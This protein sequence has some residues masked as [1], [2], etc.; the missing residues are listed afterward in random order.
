MGTKIGYVLFFL[1]VGAIRVLPACADDW[2]RPVDVPLMQAIL[3]IT[4]QSININITKDA[5]TT[6]Y[7]LQN[8]GAEDYSCVLAF[9]SP[10]TSWRGWSENNPDRRYAELA[11]TVNG[12]PV[13]YNNRSTAFLNGRNVTD[14]LAHY[15]IS[16]DIAGRPDH[17]LQNTPQSRTLYAELIEKGFFR[18]D[19]LHSPIENLLSY[20]EAW[21]VGGTYPLEPT[22]SVK[23]TYSWT[24][25]FPATVVQDIS[26]M[27]RPMWGA[28]IANYCS[29]FPLSIVSS[30]S[31]EHVAKG[32]GLDEKLMEEEQF[33]IR[34]LILP[35]DSILWNDIQGVV[36]I[37][38]DFSDDKGSSPLVFL[39]FGDQ[40]MSGVGRVKITRESTNR[41]DTV[42]VVTVQR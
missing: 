39:S 26:Y 27:F 16:P 33:I 17:W 19:V 20:G 2:N 36:S 34:W 25:A 14:T 8:T 38:A 22:W 40:S 24:Q 4:A 37:E 3:P 29:S 15:G 35:A 12:K 23:N 18:K 28:E 6:S 9:T 21:Q 32:L 5:V 41:S 13:S 30:L 11:V 42:T 7:H 10:V 31:W 1:C